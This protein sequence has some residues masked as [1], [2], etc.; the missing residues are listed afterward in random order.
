MAVGEIQIAVPTH[1]HRLHRGGIRARR[2]QAAEGLRLVQPRRLRLGNAGERLRALARAGV[3]AIVVELLA[4]GAVQVVDLVGGIAGPGGTGEIALPAAQLVVDLVVADGGLRGIQLFDAD[5]DHIARLRLQVRLVLC[6]RFRFGRRR[7]LGTGA[8][9]A[10]G[11]SSSLP[12]LQAARASG[13]S[14]PA[15]RR[16]PGNGDRE[17]RRVRVGVMSINRKIEREPR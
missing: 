14:A 8:G 2:V 13:S 7:R 17:S 15:I 3:L 6:R 5:L 1:H 10:A 12:P 9:C 11:S 4:D 16:A